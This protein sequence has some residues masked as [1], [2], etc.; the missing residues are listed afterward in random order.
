VLDVAIVGGEVVDGTGRPRRRADVG[1]R[2]GRI[3][4]IGEL[5]EPARRRIDASGR[6]VAPGFVD[7]HTHYDAQ[8]AWDPYLTP[9]PLH[10]VTTVIGG[11]CGFTL[12]PMEPEAV[13]YVTTMLARVEGM[14]LDSVRAGVDIRWRTFAE[15]LASL[16]GKTALNAGFLVG[17]STV[18]RIVLGDDWRRQATDDE[19]GAM[20]RMVSDSVAGGALGFSSSWSET[21]N[22]AAGDPIPS[23]FASE[24]ELLRLCSEL[25]QHPGTFLE[26]LPLAAGPFPHERSL[27]MA[28]MSVAAQRPLNWNLLTVRP[29]ITDEAIQS[30]LGASD[31]AT[32]HG[33][34]VYGLTLPIPQTLHINLDS[35]FLF[36]S[37]PVWAEILGHPRDEKR[38]TLADP[39]VRRRLATT[40]AEAGRIWYDVDR[41]RFE[42]VGAATYADVA[43]RTIAEAAR[44]RGVEPFDLM[45]DVAEADNLATVFVVPPQGDDPESWKRR[46]SLWEDPR[47]IIGGS[48][49]GA[50]LDMVDTFSYF[51][52]F[53]GPTVRERQLL[54]LETAVRMVTD[55]AA[56]VFGLSG[57]GRLEVGFHADVVVFDEAQVRTSPTEVRVDLP[58]N[59]M[60]LYAEAHGIDTVLVNGGLIVEDA[61]LTGEM[62]GTVLRSGHDTDTVATK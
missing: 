36:D 53:V 33:G 19:I 31:V 6:I 61:A 49:A 5:D 45:F 51:T 13:D 21:H 15:Y 35:G 41:L 55:D 29:D 38:R 46:A 18:R 4:A 1:I 9:S 10:G 52:D 23:R 3:V 2:D 26:F 14:P 58:A 40:A 8:V 62:P 60:R 22:D 54:S 48:D 44:S 47:T 17:H 43:G 34:A 16:D 37:E 7:V 59:G 24:E 20:G 32:K 27:L 25:R 28:Q 50:H 39:D 56:R 42:S 12:A 30:R 57:R 11:N